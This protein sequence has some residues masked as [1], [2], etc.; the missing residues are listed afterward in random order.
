ME[1]LGKGRPICFLGVFNANL[2]ILEFLAT[3]KY[4]GTEKKK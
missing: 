3:L 4:L 1:I 2:K